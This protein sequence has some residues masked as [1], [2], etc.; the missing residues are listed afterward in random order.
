MSDLMDIL[1]EK[2]PNLSGSS[3]YSYSS[4]LRGLH[5]RVFPKDIFNIDNFN[6]VDDIVKDLSIKPPS[7]AK[8]TYSI[9]Y[10]L[11]D[12][13]EYQKL[14]SD[15]IQAYKEEVNKQEQSQKQK[16][17]FVS[18]EE[19]REKFKQL[20]KNAKTLYKKDDI[21]SKDKQDIQNYIIL[22][23]CSG[24]IEGLPPRRSLDYVKMKIRNVTD[25][26]NY[27]NKGKFIFKVFKGSSKK[28]E[29]ELV[30]PKTLQ[31]ILNKWLSINDSDWL[32]FDSQ[33]QPLNS[34]KLT[35][36]LNKIFNKKF[37]INGLRHSFL[38]ST[39]QDTIETAK[40]MEDT[41]HKMGSSIAQEKIYINK[42]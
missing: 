16:D 33:N 18:Q 29:Q 26:D 3:L 12:K 13:P 1:K 10:I 8:T 40:K 34:T 28:G 38:S 2:R 19:I 25:E 39:F 23:L 37:S 17:N 35:Q 7:V 32:L 6:K 20:E 15:G 24:V 22:A 5:S 4:T 30:I 42:L 11:T 14:M 41:M 9:L 31:S 36:R 27:M 21:T